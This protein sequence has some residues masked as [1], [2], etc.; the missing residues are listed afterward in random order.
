MKN[1]RL[2]LLLGM[3]LV[4]SACRES[5]PETSRPPSV[6]APP[7]PPILISTGDVFAYESEGRPLLDFAEPDLVHHEMAI[8]KTIVRLRSPRGWTTSDAGAVW[9]EN[10][11][12]ISSRIVVHVESDHAAV[13]RRDWL[14]RDAANPQ[15]NIN[16]LRTLDSPRKPLLYAYCSRDDGRCGIVY[17]LLTD[18]L[19]ADSG[20]IVHGVWPAAN[21]ARLKP[22]VTAIANHVT[23]SRR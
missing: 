13:F 9:M 16:E 20:I 18:P 6:P 12:F 21:D 5:G 7:P 11:E 4:L 17:A 15:T 3:S 1:I 14:D 2:V 23:L 22:L 19:R 10:Q 8:G